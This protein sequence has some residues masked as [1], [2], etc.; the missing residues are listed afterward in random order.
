[1]VV[2]QKKAD[3]KTQGR[4]EAG[5][6][7]HVLP[8]QHR[9]LSLSPP[10]SL[11]LL[12]TERT[13]PKDSYVYQEHKVVTTKQE[14]PKKGESCCC[15]LQQGNAQL[16]KQGLIRVHRQQHIRNDKLFKA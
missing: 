8:V 12:Q 9:A 5:R 14:G 3:V 2:K 11:T 10:I 7:L 16:L 4:F 1:M 13:V 15:V 6:L